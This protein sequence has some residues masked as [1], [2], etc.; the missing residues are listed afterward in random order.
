MVFQE[1]LVSVALPS[2]VKS[3]IKDGSCTHWQAVSQLSRPWRIPPQLPVG[4]WR[5]SAEAVL[6]AVSNDEADDEEIDPELF[7]A[8]S[9]AST[10]DFATDTEDPQSES[11]EED[12][13]TVD[14]V[15]VSASEKRVLQACEIS[16]TSMGITGRNPALV[17]TNAVTG[18]VYPTPLF[19][20][21]VKG[22][23]NRTILRAASEQVMRDLQHKANWPQGLKRAGDAAGPTWDFA[24]IFKLSKQSFASFRKQWNKNKKAQAGI[25]T[26]VGDRTNRR[27][28]RSSLFYFSL[29]N[30]HCIE[31][32][33]IFKNPPAYL[34]DEVS[35]PEDDSDETQAEWE[36]RLAAA[37]AAAGITLSTTARFLEVL[38]PEWR[39]DRYSSLI[40]DRAKYR[41]DRMSEAQKGNIKFNRVGVGRRSDR[42][43][44]YAP[45]N[46]GVSAAWFN[47]HHNDSSYGNLLHDW[48][49]H[50]E[51]EDCGLDSWVPDLQPVAGPSVQ[52]VAGPVVD[53]RFDFNFE[54]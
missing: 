36:A 15:D 2:L 33:A 44:I 50:P 12:G 31:I 54:Q 22:S 43:P 47:E 51:L 41:F 52:P 8:D 28:K 27:N 7:S 18:Q 23:R 14:E 40:H 49:N 13:V 34:S 42:V 9:A 39:S 32:I 4:V 46:F 16:V 3:V 53:P 21:S 26:G 20:Y 29:N 24:Y 48:G 5:R 35:C 19:N 37:A 17:R 45:Y 25:D 30:P 10:T 1:Q 11:A 38:T 6:L